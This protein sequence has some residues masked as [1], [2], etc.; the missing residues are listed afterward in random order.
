MISLPTK[1]MM[2]LLPLLALSQMSLAAPQA[3][4]IEKRQTTVTYAQNWGEIAA[5][6]VNGAISFALVSVIWFTIAPIFGLSASGARLDT[7]SDYYTNH[8]SYGYQYADDS[9]GYE[10]PYYGYYQG[11]SLQDGVLPRVAKALFASID[12]V[13]TT[14]NYMDIDSDHCRLRTV[15]EMESYAANNPIARLAINTVNSNLRGL[16]KYS[17]AVE[18]GL[19]RQDC[20]LLY[21]QCQTSYFG[22]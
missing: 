8:H 15:C 6:F 10:D 2:M 5:S 1:M 14:F 18:A 20:A 12:I 21:D 11:R 4:S 19:A 16:E 9:Y 17:E 13:D 3:H 7:G 22:F